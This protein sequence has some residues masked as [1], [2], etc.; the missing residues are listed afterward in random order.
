MISNSSLGIFD[1]QI[2]DS[3]LEDDADFQCQVGPA[4]DQ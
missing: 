2:K 1:L 4:E 3:K